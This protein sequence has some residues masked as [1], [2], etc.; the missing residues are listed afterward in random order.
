MIESRLKTWE[1]IFVKWQ[2]TV[3]LSIQTTP[4][5]KQ[6]EEM[7]KIGVNINQ[8]AKKSKQYRNLYSERNAG[9]ERDGKE[10]LAYLKIF[11][12]KSNRQKALAILRIQKTDEKLLVSSFWLFPEA[13][14]S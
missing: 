1:L 3:I 14:E 4:L 13:S 8:I 10:F 9:I 5:K 11:P 7:H 2:L 12:I 6:Y